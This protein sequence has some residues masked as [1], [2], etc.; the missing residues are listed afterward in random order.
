MVVVGKAPDVGSTKTRLSPPLTPAQAAELYGAFL[1][2]VAALA[3]GLGWDGAT[4]IYPPRRGAEAALGA[5]CPPALA[6]RPQAGA[7]LGD[8]LADA[9]ASHL[10]AAFDQVVLIGSD[11]PT[12]PRS[13]VEMASQ[14]LV[15]HDLVIGPSADGGYYLI[16]MTRPH[17]G[18]F[19]E[20]TWSTDLVYGQ[21]LQ[22]A[23]ELGLHVAA[24][25]QWYDVDTAADLDH[26]RQ[27]LR[28]RP[29]E[30][31]PMTRAALA[32]LDEALAHRGRGRAGTRH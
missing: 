27:E 20:I 21:T 32:R 7:G 5:L 19:E 3:V 28:G 4:L 22:R 24:V 16:G 23:E 9:F 8:A 30:V 15:D 13:I 31:A 18:V 11:S 2:D 26:L 25:D 14:A 1:Q 12:L 10:A 29:P 6:L 17:L